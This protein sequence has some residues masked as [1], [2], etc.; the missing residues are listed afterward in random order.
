MLSEMLTVRSESHVLCNIK[1]SIFS[2]V[3][4]I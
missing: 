3:M 4:S 2:K 1:G